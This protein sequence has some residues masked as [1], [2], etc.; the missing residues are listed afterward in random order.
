MKPTKT[1]DLK[2]FLTEVHRGEIRQALERHFP[3]E[4]A[5]RLME[6]LNDILVL[7]KV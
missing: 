2:E 6:G 4:K 5:D 3:T 1:K 7:A